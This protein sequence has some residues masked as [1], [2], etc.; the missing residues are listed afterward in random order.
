M[1]ILLHLDWILRDAESLRIRSECGKIWTRKNSVFG[2]FSRSRKV[3]Q[4][5]L[6]MNYYE[7]LF[8]LYIFIFA[9]RDRCFPGKFLKIFRICVFTKWLIQKMMIN[10]DDK[11]GLSSTYLTL[12]YIIMKNG[13]TNFKSFAVWISQAFQ[14]T[15]HLLHKNEVFH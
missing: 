8:I 12:T 7:A 9:H 3:S 2:H 1:R 11:H 10:M 6:E 4:Y 14:I 5:P 15:D 13:Q